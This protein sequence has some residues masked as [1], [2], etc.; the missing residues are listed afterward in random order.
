MWKPIAVMGSKLF[1]AKAPS[2][3]SAV[4]LHKHEGVLEFYRVGASNM[5]PYRTANLA[6]WIFYVDLH[7]KSK[8]RAEAYLRPGLELFQGTTRTLLIAL[9]W[10]SQIHISPAY[11]EW[12]EI[13]ILIKNQN[14]NFKYEIWFFFFF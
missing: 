13:A 6:V 9:A 2:Y 3:G 10:T 1:K 8:N 12:V 7:A 5:S 11:Q 14:P 4:G